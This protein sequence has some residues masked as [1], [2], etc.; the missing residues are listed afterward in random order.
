MTQQPKPYR[1]GVISDTHGFLPAA[2][3]ERFDGVDLILHAGDIGNEHVLIEL[4][5]VAPLKAVSGNVDGP[6]QA[7]RRPLIQKIETPLGRIALLH[8]HMR[9]APARDCPAMVAFFKDFEPD[10]IIFGHTHIPFMGE[11]DGVTLFNP[12]SAGR[13]GIGRPPSIGLI[14]GNRDSGSLVIRHISLE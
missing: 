14:S 4:E 11:I 10:I 5:A 6:P 13:V 7:G 2:A 9:E 3:L 12:G 8:G 1:I